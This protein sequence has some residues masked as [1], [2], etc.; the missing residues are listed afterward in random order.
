MRHFAIVGS[1]P[2]GFYTAEALAK[3]YGDQARIDGA[4]D[5]ALEH[6]VGGDDDNISLHVP[7]RSVYGRR[8]RRL[9]HHCAVPHS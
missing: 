1:G 8:L 7:P 3:V 5:V 4:W 2:A 9:A 6:L